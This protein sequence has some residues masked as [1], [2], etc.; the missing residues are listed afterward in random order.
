MEVTFYGAVREVTGSMHVITAN[1]DKIML[2]CGMFQGRRKDTV[3]KNKEFSFDPKSIVN[4]VLSHAHVDHCGRIPLL[5]KNGFTG[6]ILCTRPT[7]DVCAFLLADSAHIQES[8]ANYLNYKTLRN[9]LL[10]KNNGKNKNHR[11][12][13]IASMLKTEGHKL[14]VEKIHD[15]IKEHDLEYISPLYTIEDAQNSLEHFDSYPYRTSFEIGRGITGVLYEAGHI[16]GSAIPLIK[17]NENGRI[18][19]ICYTGDIGRYDKPIIRNPCAAF[20]DEDKDIDLLIMESTYGDREHEDMEDVR[21]QLKK[22]INDT[23]ERGGSIV[24]PAFAFGRTQELLYIIHELYHG[25]EVPRIPVYVDSPLATNITR[26]FGEHPEVYSKETMDTFLSKGDNPFSFKELKF[27]SSVDES[28]VLMKDETP[29]IVLSASGMCEAG[30]VLHHLRYKIH[31]PK[32]TILLVGFMAQN[33]LGRRI[34]DQGLEYE[35]SGRKGDPPILKFLN[36]EYP[37]KAHVVKLG[38]FSAHGDKN[39][40]LRFLKDSKLKIKNIAVVHGEEDQSIAFADFLSENG[41]SAFVPEK[42]YTLKLT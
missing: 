17:I 25:G 10:S 26:V 33:T 3:Q 12:S 4:L 29:H 2:D 37:L 21:P 19:R 27:V 11:K 23:V 34:H 41:Y 18:F 30:R 14:N 24:I 39:E 15:L 32:N 28:M 8:D 38:A 5:V 40:M 1:S 9:T 13:E 31:N 7:A 35:K 20:P 6:R 16:L 22:I 36:K 42:D